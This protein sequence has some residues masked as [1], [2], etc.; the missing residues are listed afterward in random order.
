MKITR[1]LAYAAIGILLVAIFVVFFGKGINRGTPYQQNGLGVSGEASSWRGMSNMMGGDA[2]ESG[3]TTESS[4]PVAADAAGSGYA[5]KMMAAENPD[6][7]TV[8]PDMM[9]GNSAVAETEKRVVRNGDLSIRV[10]DAEW[11]ADEIDRIATRLGGFTASRSISSSMPGYPMPMVQD[12]SMGYGISKQSSN[13]PQTGVVIIKIPSDKFAEANAAI[14]GIASV[15]L[16]ESSSA[17]DVTAQFADLEARIKN[18]YA[19]EEA[20]TKILNT[21]LG[22]VADVLQVT[23]ELSR[24]RGEIEQLETQKKYMESQ[25]DMASISV[26]LS[27]D[28]KVGTTTNSWRPWQTVKSAVNALISQCRNFIDGAIYFVVSVVPVFLLYLLGVYVVYKIGKGI[29]RRLYPRV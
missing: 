1:W 14:R 19:E 15:V 25:T 6:F 20:F 29:Y 5:G 21:T 22:K 18:K 24:V 2:D 3:V 9:E 26:S 28:V 23:R 13:A 12:E 10:E 16:N 11:S 7:S 17:S 8:A 4:V 27:E